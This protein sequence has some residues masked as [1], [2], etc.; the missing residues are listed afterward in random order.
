MRR[1]P[2][3][4]AFVAFS[5]LAM[6]VAAAAYADPPQQ[7][8]VRTE[9]RADCASYDPL[10]TPFFGETHIHTSFSGDAAFVR[11]R[12]TPRDAYRFARG[13][14][15][16]LPPYDALD[17]PT[18]SAQLRRPLDF[19]A[20]T[21]HSEFL[22]EIR[23]C[24]TAGLPGYDD[25]ICQDARAELASPPDGIT[26]PIPAVVI[27]FQLTIQAANPMRLG[28]CGPGN[29]NCLTQAALV[30]QDELDAA[31]EFYDRTD[32]CAFTTFP[33]YEWTNNL[34]G[35]NLHRNIIFR[36]AEVP[37]LPTS[38]YEQPLVEGLWSVLET[39]CLDA[40]GNCDFVSIPHNSNVSG[41]LMFE[42]KNGDG[43]PLTRADAERRAG[44]E[45]LVEVFQH[46]GSSECQPSSSP[47][48]ELCGFEQLQRQQLF[49]STLKDQ[50]VPAR[51]FV[52]NALMEGL[53]LQDVLG[54]NPFALGFVGGTDGHSSLAGGVVEEDFG[55]TG[56]L[57]VRDGSAE[58]ILSKIAPGGIV[59]NGGGLTVLWA[60]ENSRDAL[61]AAMR[62]REAYATS[63]TRP[64]VRFFGG[65]PPK[66]ACEDASFVEEGY[67]H[68]V[69]MG[70][71]IGPALG[72]RSPR[73]AVMA[74]RDP[75]GNGEPSTP[76]E[77]V[78]IVKGWADADGQVHE[79]VFEVAGDARGKAGVDLATCAP[80]G[81][82]A[83]SLCAVWQDPS[84]RPEER[85]FYY[86]RVLE[87]PV[88]RWSKRLCNALA[89]DCTDFASVPTIYRECC[90]GLA[91][92]TIQERAW[93]SPIY[94]QPERFGTKGQIRFGKAPASDRLR[95]ELTIGRLPAALDVVANGLTVTVTDDDAVY[96]ATLPAGAFATRSPGRNYLY[97]DPTGSVDGVKK[98][99]LRI[100]KH[101]TA[102]L[103]LDTVRLDLSN[104]GT[105]THRVDVRLASGAYDQ[106]DGRVWE[107]LRGKLKASR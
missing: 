17:Q 49:S 52:R 107:G 19:T 10:R 70:G 88:C 14:Q 36:N 77:R 29:V 45:T 39:D 28:L 104:A 95:L 67:T 89:V 26:A 74:L 93:T 79:R 50:P 40:A 75:G 96:A 78:Q 61:F 106:S 37:A 8:W 72:R 7:D 41:G 68:G 18:R 5:C 30:W 85:A 54:A 35:Y 15:I 94:Y 16:A 64:I 51:N 58:N 91:D 76:L 13:E 43:S 82:G 62:R 32:A 20:V 103:T 24:L 47:N 4:F 99:R 55:T 98:A 38:Y 90:L 84:F 59:T 87:N 81:T 65:H 63:G 92:D 71:E 25:P 1:P 105:T 80:T 11:V 101:G 66:G 21:D 56:H 60:E 12:T 69:P 22:G 44:H 46:K 86:A 23:T 97:D 9:S 33:A 73:F 6:S 34:D 3:S 48:D 27:A 2:R 31:E 102:T 57:G 53:R 83:S 100:N 42:S